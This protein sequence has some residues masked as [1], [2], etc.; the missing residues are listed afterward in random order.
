MGHLYQFAG[1]SSNML[2]AAAGLGTVGCQVLLRIPPLLL[3]SS[4]S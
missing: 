1:S 3:G 4:V 2:G